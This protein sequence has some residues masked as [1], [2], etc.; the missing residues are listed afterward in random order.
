M[1]S[2]VWL[3][4]LLIVAAM[5]ASACSFQ[6]GTVIKDDSSGNMRVEMGYTADEK[7]LLESFDSGSDDLCAQMQS[8]SESDTSDLPP[9]AK[10]FQEQRGDETVCGVLVPFDNLDELRSVYKDMDTAVNQ[11]SLEDG[12]LVYDVTVDTTS[13]D[14]GGFPIDISWQLSVPGRVGDNNA[15][16]VEGNTLTWDLPSGQM[17]HIHAES[18]ATPNWMWWAI[19]IGA[20]CLCLVLLVT[21]SVVIFFLIRRNKK[22]LSNEAPSSTTGA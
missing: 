7:S 1:K 22:E 16:K 6:I 19:G 13:M 21:V 4:S 14:V 8:E 3:A 17:V 2:R 12:Q 15:N 11:L 9:D 5:L 20:A 18:S 10:F